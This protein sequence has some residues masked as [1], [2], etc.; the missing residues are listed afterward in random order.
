MF[1]KN[2]Y[3]T[4]GVNEHL[5]FDL[6]AALWIKVQSVKDRELDYLQVFEFKNGGTDEDPL[7]EVKWSQEVPEYNESF[8]V[9]GAKTDVDKVWIICSGEGTKQEYSTMLLPEEY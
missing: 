1:E 4:K 9:K 3:I 8:Y 7:L 5:S 2:T 6:I